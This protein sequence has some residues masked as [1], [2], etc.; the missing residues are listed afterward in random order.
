MILQNIIEPDIIS[1]ITTYR[2]TAAC[3]DCCFQCS[4]HQRE[5]LTLEQMQYFISKVTA[6][7]PSI[8][9]VAITG[10]ECFT[11]GE[12]L[13]NLIIF[14]RKKGLFSRIVTNGSWATTLSKSRK[15]IHRLQ[16][17]GLT[18]INFSTGD[19]HQQYVPVQNVI[20]GVVAAQESKMMTV[21]N[22]ETNK[23]FTFTAEEF[24]KNPQ[25]T[26]YIN[27]PYLQ[28]IA[29]EWIQFSDKSTQN[30]H[31]SKT[32][33][34]QLNRPN[35]CKQL[36]KVMTLNPQNNLICCCGLS[37]RKH[38]FLSLGTILNRDIKKLWESQFDDFVKLWLYAE[39]PIKILEFSQKIDPSIKIDASKMHMCALCLQILSDSH[40]L[41]I[42][43]ENYVKI[44]PRVMLEYT[45]QSQTKNKIKQNYEK[46]NLKSNQSS[47][48]ECR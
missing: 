16:S 47:L 38:P 48:T 42:I 4:P 19:S 11:L 8:K 27:T 36:F 2:C 7:Y 5:R 32:D 37:T 13:Y 41:Q 28:I 20:N 15:I 3:K 35:R 26:P 9:L 43:R 12:D 22:V 31:S 14:I 46:A 10:G 1:L 24:R 18:E 34:S 21:V 17:V 29:G 6:I 25:L 23:N 30:A 33:L 45:I 39:G 40:I 44:A